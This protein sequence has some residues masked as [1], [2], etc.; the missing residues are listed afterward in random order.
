MYENVT[1]YLVQLIHANKKVMKFSVWGK[2]YQWVP[3]A[4]RLGPKP[5]LTLWPCMGDTSGLFY[6]AVC[7]EIGSCL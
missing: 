5:D 2:V 7:F 1:L 6:T 4:A 3:P